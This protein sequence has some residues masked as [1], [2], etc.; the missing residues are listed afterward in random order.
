[1]AFTLDPRRQRIFA[2]LSDAATVTL[3]ELSTRAE[4]TRTLAARELKRLGWVKRGHEYR[5]PM[6]ERLSRREYQR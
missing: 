6:S 4:V 3:D 1:M 5:S 2:A